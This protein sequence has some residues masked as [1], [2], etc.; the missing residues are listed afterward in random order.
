MSKLR[1]GQVMLLWLAVSILMFTV[2]GS[3][4]RDLVSSPAGT[5]V[6]VSVKGSD[7]VPSLKGLAL[8]SLVIAGV[9]LFASR[10]VMLVVSAVAAILALVVLSATVGKL[11]GGPAQVG[12]A[13]HFY[14][15][16]AYAAL[17]GILGVI[18]LAVST[19]LA[20]KNWMVARYRSAEKK[21]GVT[22]L[23]LWR[24]QDSG[25]DPTADDQIEP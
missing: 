17:L 20:A 7:L 15:L 24:A 11:N 16:P 3:S 2:N 8:L 6:H 23:D 1:R 22:Q 25:V 21:P 19:P 4:W 14:W 5:I 13:A 18:A 9:S 10:V 12:V